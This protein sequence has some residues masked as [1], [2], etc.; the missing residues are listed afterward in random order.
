M[1]KL[2]PLITA[3]AAAACAAAGAQ[4]QTSSSLRPPAEAIATPG[5]RTALSMSERDFMKIAAQAGIAEVQAAQLALSRSSD[6]V[7][8][9]FA[10]RMVQDHTRA[11]ARLQ[12]L[13]RSKSVALPSKPSVLDQSKLRVLEAAEGADFDRQ[14]TDEFGLEAHR[15]TLRQFRSHLGRARDADL[16]AYVRDVL[17]QLEQHLQL[18]Q[19]TQAKLNEGASR[20]RAA[21]ASPAAAG[22]GA[23]RA[24]SSEAM[25]ARQELA[26]AVQVVQRMKTDPGVT[27][28]LRRAKGVFIMPSYGRAA[29]GVGVQGGQGVLVTRKGDGF[30]NPVFFNLA[31]IS[32]GP[33]AGA[34]GGEVAFLLMTDKAVNDFKSGKKFSLNA[35]AGL[36]IANYSRRAHAS[37]G[38]VQDVIVWSGSRGAYAGLSIGLNDVIY[39]TK[40]NRAYYGRED[41]DPSRIIDGGVQTPESNV[42]AIVLAV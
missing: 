24:S 6:P 18:A 1:Q 4:A 27:D 31:G 37:A 11:N 3:V 38:K 36:T 25:E 15:S 35:D 9:E 14:Y 16:Q 22:M 10:T 12:Q 30:S 34:A 33:Q 28:L 32:V 13:A 41:L 40:I 7:V 5:V 21:T 8:R 39:N 20:Q 19:D 26:E 42:L 2:H 17:P 29:L 23:A